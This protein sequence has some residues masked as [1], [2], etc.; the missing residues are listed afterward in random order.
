VASPRKEE[1]TE[2]SDLALRRKLNIAIYGSLIVNIFLFALQLT[3]AILSGSLA[4]LATMADSF[5]DLTSNMVLSITNYASSKQN[6]LKYPAGKLVYS[7]PFL[8]AEK[9]NCLL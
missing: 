2:E 8:L 4:L 9:R 1:N 6:L 5:M 7:P 3:A